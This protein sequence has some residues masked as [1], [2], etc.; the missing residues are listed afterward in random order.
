MFEIV[1]FQ[2]VSNFVQSQT[3]HKL[4][5]GIH[6]LLGCPGESWCTLS[7][8][9]RELRVAHAKLG[10]VRFH[11]VF[12]Q[13]LQVSRTTA[14]GHF[15]RPM[16]SDDIR[17]AMG[18]RR[19][20]EHTLR[21]QRNSLCL[22]ARQLADFLNRVVLRAY[23][24]KNHQG[25]GHFAVIKY[26]RFRVEVVVHPGAWPRRTIPTQVGSGCRANGC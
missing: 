6:Q 22:D 19:A 5:F 26:H 24:V 23:G 11:T 14:R 18:V 8:M 9:C 4:G 20:H 16:N 17:A 15:V 12:D 10:R 7:R 13:Q 25:H 2:D 1:W 21:R 3:N